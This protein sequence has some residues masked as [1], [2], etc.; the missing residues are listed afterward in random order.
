MVSR[1][2]PFVCCIAFGTMSL[3][4]ESPH[5][6][7][8]FDCRVCHAL[9]LR[10]MR[11][12]SVFDHAATGFVLTER[13]R[14]IECV[15]CHESLM[16]SSQ[17][18]R[19]SPCHADVHRG[20][21][22]NNCAQCH[23][24]QAWLGPHMMRGHEKGRLLLTGAHEAV[25]CRQCHIDGNFKLVF[26]VCYQCHQ[27]QYQDAK[28]PDHVTTNFNHDCALCH[29]TTGWRPVTFD[30]GTT[31][32]LMTGAHTRTPCQSCH[33]NSD[34]RLQYV[35]CY[36]CHEAQFKQSA[37]PNHVMADFPHDCSPCHSTTVWRPS[38]FT[39]DQQ[40]FRIFVG[41]H[42]N[43]WSACSDCHQYPGNFAA[44]SCL[45]CHGEG[46]T[47][48]RHLKATGYTYASPACYSCHREA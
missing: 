33:V 5:G 32:F 22:G 1:V 8:K 19:C 29:A 34:Y 9:N 30:H 14:N 26:T 35:N 44:Y 43:L 47:N 38:V 11:T 28:K 16:F 46:D 10:E 6:P 24:T 2:I 48:A 36:Q 39:H 31:Q 25:P 45:G 40:N 42:R 15:A 18:P 21:R 3:A 4:R 20:E 27:E 13:H 7:V 17:A 37:N 12:D 23:T 41:R